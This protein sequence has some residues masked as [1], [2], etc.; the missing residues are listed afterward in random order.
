MTTLEKIGNPPRTVRPVELPSGL[1]VHVRAL[2]LAETRRI[3]AL[4]DQVLD[5]PERNERYTLLVCAFGLAEE[6]GA[7]VFPHAV[8][9]APDDAAVEAALAA[10]AALEVEQILKIAGEVLGDRARAKNA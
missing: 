8:K 3:D 9:F 5:G 1:T 7:A 6:D 2:T 4:A 10:V